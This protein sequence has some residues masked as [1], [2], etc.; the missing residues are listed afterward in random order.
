M[1]T[2]DPVVGGVAYR[3]DRVREGDAFFCIPGFKVD[4]HSFAADAA[5]RGA[6]ALVVEHPVDVDLPQAVVPDARRAL[7]LASARAYGQPTAS[8]DVVGITGTNGKT[9]TTYLVDAILRAAGRTTGIIGTVETRVAGERLSSARTTPESADLQALF[10]EMLDH[11]V[12]A[13]AIEVSSHAIDLHRVDGVHFAVAAFTNLTQDHLDYHHTLEEY[14]AVKRRLL[15]DLDVSGRVVNIDDEYGRML[16]T[17]LDITLTVGRSVDA[18]V[19]AYVER[20]DAA[21]TR[22]TLVTPDGEVDI[23]LPLAGEYNVS[24]ALVA[25]GCALVLGVDLETI[26]AG[27]ESAPQVPGRLE[28][29]DAGQSFSVLVDYAHTPDSLKKAIGAVRAVTTG[30]VITVFG[31]GGDR[32]PEKRPLMG[33]A[34]GEGSD[35]VIVTSDNPRTEDPV[36]IILHIED[37]LR[38]TGTEYSV[39]VDRR[40]AIAMA[41]A[42]ARDGDS[43]L[44]AGKGHEDYQV[45]L[46]RTIHFD[47]REVA[48]E[49]LETLC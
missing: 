47:D 15:S 38:P 34:A 20:P 26:A 3:S 9:T 5:G 16:A 6:V 23:R 46:D 24:N 40:R 27:L 49:E 36:G 2:G 25:A 13:A 1:T 12:D 4:G 33:A 7:A 29:I 48:R 30:R 10:C 17:E 19:R 45:F 41:L 8:M 44:I 31:C 32:D 28:R 21:S 39:E 43:V 35:L 22:F 11:G 18:D 14:F 42:E 37:G